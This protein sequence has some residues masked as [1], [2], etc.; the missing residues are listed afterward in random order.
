MSGLN[1]ILPG[2]TFTTNLGLAIPVT[3]G[4]M[5]YF[6]P[7]SADFND[8]D[9]SGSGV[10]G[11]LSNGATYNTRE[12]HDILPQMGTANY[13]FGAYDPNI[14]LVSTPTPPATLIA[15]GFNG[16]SL[17]NWYNYTQANITLS[18]DVLASGLVTNTQTKSGFEAGYTGPVLVPDASYATQFKFYACVQN[19][20]SGGNA[21]QTIYYGS[22]GVLTSVTA[23][24]SAIA[25]SGTP[26]YQINAAHSVNSTYNNITTGSGQ[27]KIAHQAVHNVA[28]TATEIA[29][30]YAGLQRYFSSVL[31]NYGL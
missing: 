11:I 24:Q 1:I 15:V 19:W 7:G 27:R 26:S 5:R 6:M 21:T 29:A 12:T 13:P 17:A 2:V 3:R 10:S 25:Q 9:L 30:A 14:P 20:V 23:S 18:L 8:N 4:L 16:V 31:P 28:L 22:N